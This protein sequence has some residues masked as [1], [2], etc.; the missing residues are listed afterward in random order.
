MDQTNSISMDPNPLPLAN[1]G[2]MPPSIPYI[3]GNEAAE[4]FS[5]YGMKAILTTFLAAQF[6]ASSAN[7]NAAANE[8]THAF[9]AMTYL[10]PLVGG[11]LAD[12]FLGKYKTIL[13]LSLLYCVGHACLAAFET[14]LSGFTMGLMFIS[15]GAGGIKPCVSAN[16]GD[17]FDRSNQH[18]MSKVFNAF[19]FSIN[20]GSFFSTLLIPYTLKHYGPAVAFGLPGILMAVATFIFWLGR[21]KYVHIEPKGDSNKLMIFLNVV[22]ALAISYYVCDMNKG[23][24][25][26]FLDGQGPLLLMT[27]LLVILSAFI[28][29]KQWFATPGNFIGIN[30]YALTHGGFK[31]AENRYTAKT[32]EGIKAVWNVLLVFAFIPIFWALYDQNGSEWVLQAQNLN[33]NFMGVEWQA[34]Q[35]QAINPILILTFI[36]L[37]TFLLFPFIEKMGVKVTPLRKIGVG[38][39][40]T[41]IS[42]IIIATLQSWIDA[43]PMIADASGKMVRELTNAPNIVWQLLAYAVLT[44]AEVLVSITGLEYAYTQAPKTMKSTIMACFLLTVTLGN[45]LVAQINNS[46][47]KGGF[48]AQFEGASYYWLFFGVICAFTLLYFF[49]APRIK[50]HSYVGNED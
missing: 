31:A 48:F 43:L 46:I 35:V 34:E 49:I 8:Q 9:I 14:S 2:K 7:P 18:L 42:F 11:M 25:Y 24:G 20:F 22:A 44:A 1:K 23:F 37:F 28:F 40:L 12:W 47:S 5:F 15:M 13:Y 10:L 38:L 36:P 32:V 6:F 27:L 19:Y 4:R 39:V 3:I 41:A 17:Q 16:V 45:V 30:L 21:D 29:Q 33:R 26:A 50:E